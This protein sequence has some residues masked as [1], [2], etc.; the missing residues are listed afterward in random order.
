M[1]RIIVPVDFG[2][3]S[4]AALTYAR[5]LALRYDSTVILIH[6][7]PM[8]GHGVIYGEVIAIPPALLVRLENHQETRARK[9][10][11][12][13]L[14]QHNLGELQTVI[15]LSRGDVAEAVLAEATSDDL[16]VLGANQR[17]L[18][19][20]GLGEELCRESPCPVLACHAIDDDVAVTAA[21]GRGVVAVDGSR[22]AEDVAYAA[23]KIVEPGGD[24]EFLHVIDPSPVHH[25]ETD[26]SGA[27]TSASKT[28]T[29]ATADTVRAFEQWIAGQDLGVQSTGYIANNQPAEALLERAVATE[30]DFIACGAHRDD[31][32]NQIGLA[33]LLVRHAPVPVLIVNG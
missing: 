4:D 1:K 13:K 26:I 23:A 18:T 17:H 3:A 11:E 5:L 30:A 19:R 22:L 20:P 28:A 16:V 10:L 15:K 6:V 24:I 12:R 33:E 27:T 32:K 8:T 2:P 9:R 31:D 25:V 29:L 7:L 14:H 21:F